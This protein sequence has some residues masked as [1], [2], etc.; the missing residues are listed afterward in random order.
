[1][2]NHMHHLNSSSLYT[3]SLPLQLRILQQSEERWTGPQ[4][5]A[6]PDPVPDSASVFPNPLLHPSDISLQLTLSDYNSTAHRDDTNPTW[7]RQHKSSPGR[8]SYLYYDEDREMT[9]LRARL[10]LNRASTAINRDRGKPLVL[11]NHSQCPL[12][13][14]HT[15]TIQHMLLECTHPKPTRAR[16]RLTRQLT[17][18]ALHPPPAVSLSTIL[19][20]P[21]VPLTSSGSIPAARREEYTTLLGITNAYLR[22]IC[23]V[24]QHA[25]QPT[26]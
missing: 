6:A 8:S 20:T 12:C 1:M 4:P 11:A 3:Q 24:R 13:L 9:C 16:L 23:F 19:G 26:L 7:L 22:T 10:R 15:E 21:H 14:T 17:R 5:L 2:Q 25:N 18:A